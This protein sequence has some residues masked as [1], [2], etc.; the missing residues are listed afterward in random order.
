MHV[1]ALQKGVKGE[2]NK[3]QGSAWNRGGGIFHGGEEGGE[4]ETRKFELN[5][6]T[7]LVSSSPCPFARFISLGRKLIGKSSASRE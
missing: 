7:Y 5:Y 4:Q 2:H 6:Y 1:R 3:R